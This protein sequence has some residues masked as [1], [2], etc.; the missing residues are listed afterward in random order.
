MTNNN[1]LEFTG[2]EETSDPLTELLKSG[3]QQL[4]RHQA[5]AKQS[6]HDI[7][8]AETKADAE[9][10]FDLFIKSRASGPAILLNRHSGQSG[11]APGA[12]KGAS[13]VT[14]CCT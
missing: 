11:N 10:A 9:K 13:R 5:K 7:W 1:V 12:Q 4:I 3:A 2:R 8:Q 6:L 14:A